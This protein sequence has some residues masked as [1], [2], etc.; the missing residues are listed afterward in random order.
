MALAAAPPS[1]LDAAALIDVVTQSGLRGRGG[2]GFPT[3]AKWSTIAGLASDA[4]PTTVVVNGAE[5]EPGTF[6]DRAILRANPYAVLEGARDRRSC[7]RRAD[8][9]H[10]PQGDVR[11]RGRTGRSRRSPRWKPPGGSTAACSPCSRDR[12]ST[13]TARRRRCSRP[14]PVVRRS[15]A[16]PRRGA[17]A[18]PSVVERR[19]RRGERE[20][21]RRSGADGRADGG[22]AGAGQQRR[23]DRQ[24]AGDRRQR[25]RVVPLARHRRVTGHD[26]VHRQR[27]DEAGRGRRD[28]DGHAARAR[29]SRRSAAGSTSDAAS[30]PCLM[31]VANAVLT[32]DQLD[33]PMT[34][35]AMRDAGQ[36]ARLGRGSSCSPT[37]STCSPPPPGVARFLAVESCGQCTPC[38]QR[39]SRPRRT[40]DGVVRR[41]RRAGDAATIS[42]LLRTVA[43]GARCALAGQQQS[44]VGSL[45]AL[46]GQRPRPP[47]ADGEAEPAGPLLVAELVD[48]DDGKAVYDEEFAEQAARLD[49]RR[50][51]LR[52]VARRPPHRQARRLSAHQLIPRLRVSHFMSHMRPA[53]VGSRPRSSSWRAAAVAVIV[54]RARPPRSRRCAG[55]P[56]GRRGSG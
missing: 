29:P 33:T 35:E 17:A 53:E 26:R 56:P 8:G 55:G 14:S 9:R 10:R 28:P 23:D 39:R 47:V 18:P 5:G 38:K 32:G 48:I 44:A 40:A 25:R 24:R 30:P 43:D 34:Y 20:R 42:D 6:K 22:S 54:P 19:R 46:A 12:G 49:L 52:P 15:R 16:S 11:P 13:S 31:G 51:R 4:L 27:F 41:V 2:A 3:G 45:V 50:D 7:R 1:T 36:R 37:T 21:A